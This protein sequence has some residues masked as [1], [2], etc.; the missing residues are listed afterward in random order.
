MVDSG[1]ATVARKTQR[2]KGPEK[3]QDERVAVIV[4]K[5]TPDYRNWLIGLSEATLISTA[6]I[7]RDALAKWAAERGLPAPPTVP[8]RRRRPRGGAK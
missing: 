8:G 4:L 3:A 6:T 1:T 7:V 2:G 5:D